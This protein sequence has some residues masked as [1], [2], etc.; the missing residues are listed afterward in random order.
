MQDLVRHSYEYEVVVPCRFLFYRWYKVVTLRYTEAS[1][2]DLLSYIVDVERWHERSWLFRFIDRYGNR[3]L[4]S[5]DRQYIIRQQEDIMYYIRQ[6]YFSGSFSDDGGSE[7]QWLWFEVIVDS[8]AERWWQLPTMI[9]SQ[10]SLRQM[11]AYM[12]W[13]EYNINM[14]TEEWQKRNRL[15]AIEK[16]AEQKTI[17]EKTQIQVFL[18]SDT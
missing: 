8:L 13:A 18:S 16:R 1:I 11:R 7:W 12:E 9:T 5:S 10:M 4:S 2:D 14:S 6:T 3:K 15:K 17:E